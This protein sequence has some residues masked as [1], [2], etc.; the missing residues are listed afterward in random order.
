MHKQIYVNIPITDLA[1][2][3]AFYAALGF[4][5]DPKFANEH[6]ACLIVGDG[7]YTMLV[8]QDFLQTLTPKK[9]GDVA[10]TTT[11]LVSVSCASREEVDALV[12][13]A[14]AN[15]GRA[16]PGPDDEGFMY[17]HAFDDP[18]G[19]GWGLFCMAAC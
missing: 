1:R 4:E 14:V 19:N 10:T 6:G 7:I 9:I 18:D 13:K 5:F 3:K 15:G 12:A 2:S 8:K 17:S 11:A 16:H